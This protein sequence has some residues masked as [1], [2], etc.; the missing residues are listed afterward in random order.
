MTD[1]IA[2]HKPDETQPNQAEALEESVVERFPGLDGIEEQ[3]FDTQIA[4]YS[5]VLRTLEQELQQHR[6]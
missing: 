5:E 3:D 2:R 4:S 6:S 1:D